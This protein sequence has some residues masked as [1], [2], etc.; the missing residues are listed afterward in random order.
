M[1][2][3]AYDFR[4]YE[5]KGRRK[6]L[7]AIKVMQTEGAT[8]TAAW[9]PVPMRNSTGVGTVLWDAGHDSESEIYASMSPRFSG[10]SPLDS[11]EAVARL[12]ALQERGADF[13]LF[14]RS[15]FWWLDHYPEFKSHL[16]N[17]CRLI[18]DPT[19]TDGSCIIFDLL[20]FK[21]ELV[22]ELTTRGKTNF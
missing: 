9:E 19:A 4:L 7:A 21:T 15:A 16:E 10:Y 18:A 2:G 3:R 11:N 22:S 12:E 13:L 8:L 20:R 5:G 14:P 1:L 17:H 6:L